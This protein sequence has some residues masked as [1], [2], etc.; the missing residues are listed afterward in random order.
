MAQVAISFA[1]EEPSPTTLSFGI[2]MGI[3]LGSRITVQTLVNNDVH[4]EQMD[5]TVN[6]GAA[7]QPTQSILS[8]GLANLGNA[9]FSGNIIV[10]SSTPNTNGGGIYIDSGQVGSV[11]ENNIACNWMQDGG[12]PSAC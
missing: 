3:I 7:F 9:T 10:H 12:A 2:H 8:L 1:P 5:N 6:G 4:I 11:V